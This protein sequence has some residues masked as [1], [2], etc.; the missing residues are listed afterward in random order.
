MAAYK[1]AFEDIL[2][3]DPWLI[4]EKKWERKLQQVRETQFTLGNGYIC[5]RGIL[6]E[7]PYDSTPG[8]FI[9][10]IF[11]RTG[12]QITELVN[13]PNPLIF[14]FDAYGEKLDP[15]ATD[16]VHH[17]RILDLKKAEL[18]RH[19]IY[20]TTHKKRIDYRSRRFISLHNKNLLV[21][22]IELTPLDAAMTINVQTMIDT[23]VSNRGTVTEGR[24]RH[25]QP[26]DV[27]TAADVAYLCVETFEKKEKVAYAAAVQICRKKCEQLETEQALNLRVR[28]G[29]KIF[30]RK[31]VAICNSSEKSPAVLRRS[32]INILKRAVKRGFE[33][34]EKDHINE[35][36]KK[37][38]IADIK[39]E[40]DAEA[41]KALRFNMYHLLISSTEDNDDVSIGAKTMSGEGYRG[42][43]FW[44]TELFILPFFI[45]TNPTIAK[46]LLLYRYHRLGAARNNAAAKGYK[47]VLFPWESADTGEECTPSWAKNFD[48]SIIKI[49]T[50][51]EEHHI[52]ADIAYAFDHY[53]QATKDESFW[54]KYGLEIMVES[55]RF[56]LSRLTYNKRRKKYELH[57]VMGPDEFHEDVKNNAFSNMMA[58]WNL[59]TA[60]NWYTQA[61]KKNNKK[62]SNLNRRLKVKLTEV[63]AWAEIADNIYIPYS[64]KKKLIEPFEG[65][66]KLEDHR[67]TQL[68]DH[69][70]PCLP[71]S[72]NYQDIGK[73]QLI[74]QADVVMLLYLFS[75]KFS[76]KEKHQNY[77]YNEKRT[78]HKSSLSPAIHSIVGLEVGDEDK[79]L[80]YFAHALSTDLSDIH[81]NTS[82]GFH[83]ASGGG[84]WQAL[85]L[86]FAGMR[87]K[88]GVLS[89]NPHLP[90]HWKYVCFK[91]YWQK[92]LI[93]VE[94]SHHSIRISCLKGPAR[95]KVLVE[96][97]DERK[98]VSP[99]K[100]VCF[101]EGI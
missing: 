24:K 27:K 1:I 52:V 87:H 12:A 15:I 76:L 43:I 82:D 97:A 59:R 86:G 35:W 49:V 55:A 48:G 33:R 8:T 30:F 101:K 64:K 11:D 72:T 100:Q 66:F 83:A 95:K 44:D 70:M 41:A 6:E 58:A 69:L 54:W 2:S 81:G 93:E 94:I 4:K 57:H 25:Y 29:E 5:S 13:F 98:E 47:G 39:I 22:E 32:T 68:D 34:L 65:F 91:V 36:V 78:L 74:K 21:M 60:A 80:H 50:L 10:G 46:N 75:D 89:F 28:K 79:A 51:D 20:K 37:W 73:T 62:L 56:W 71:A 42:H 45:Y 85:V 96:V 16:I 38:D 17:Q 40:G 88:Q 67:I 63:N 7:V 84:T 90:Q 18:F 53:Y 99:H 19:T 23:G 92:C 3:P 61:K 77:F 9:N 14:R 26:I 31:F